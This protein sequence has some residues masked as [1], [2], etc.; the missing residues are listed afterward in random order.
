MSKVLYIF[1]LSLCF[2]EMLLA[3]PPVEKTVAKQPI[4][5]KVYQVPGLGQLY[6]QETDDLV[7][8]ILRK[9]QIWEGHYQKN[10]F[11]KYVKKGTTVIDIGAFVGSHTVR[12][13]QLASPGLVHAFEPQKDIFEL[14]V[15]NAKVNNLSNIISHNVALGDK[16]CGSE[17]VKG[18]GFT[19]INRGATPVQGCV[20]SGKAAFEMFPLD[21]FKLKNVSFI[22]IDAEGS[23][24]IIIKGALETIKQNRPVMFIEVSDTPQEKGK[25]YFSHHEGMLVKDFLKMMTDLNYRY[26]HVFHADYLFIPNEYQAESVKSK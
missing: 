21:H 4:P 1:L 23:E 15:K 12:L 19:D 7:Q 11:E 13:A 5:V 9:G 8:N 20:D 3:S 26:E 24:P 10:F 6:L 25:E 16:T 2:V 17:I 18:L 14:L 22:K